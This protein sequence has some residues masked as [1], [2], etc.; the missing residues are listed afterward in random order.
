MAKGKAKAEATTRVGVAWRQD[1]PMSQELRNSFDFRTEEGEPMEVEL[2]VMNAQEPDLGLE[3]YLILAESGERYAKTLGGLDLVARIL[4]GHTG[5]R[6]PSIALLS[7]LDRDTL[8]QKTSNVD[9]FIV[10]SFPLHQ[11]PPQGPITLRLPSVTKW[12]YLCKYALTRSGILNNIRHAVQNAIALGEAGLP[13]MQESVKQ[14]RGLPDLLDPDLRGWLVTFDT[15]S[16]PSEKLRSSA[17]LL[18][19]LDRRI[20]ALAEPGATRPASAARRK[21][22]VMLVEDEAPTAAHVMAM[23]D[24]RFEVVPF[25]DG[26]E[27]LKELDAG[28]EQY[29]ALVCDLE[30]LKSNRFDQPAIGIDVLE[31][32]ASHHPHIARRVITGLGRRGVHELL[33]GM[34]VEHVLFKAHL[35]HGRDSLFVEFLND[36]ELD[37]DS[38]RV[39]KRMIGPRNTNWLDVSRE[40]QEDSSGGGYKSFYYQLQR[41][42]LDRFTKMWLDIESTID[43]VVNNQDVKIKCDFGG[44][45]DA[46]TKMEKIDRE[47]DVVFLQ[48]LLTHRLVMLTKYRPGERVWYRNEDDRSKSYKHL[49]F[50]EG[51]PLM[52]PAIY[53]GYLG[54]G[55]KNQNVKTPKEPDRLVYFDLKYEQLFLEELKVLKKYPDLRKA[56]EAD[57]YFEHEDLCCRLQYALDVIE[58]QRKKEPTKA[59]FTGDYPK[60]PENPYEID[61]AKAEIFLSQLSSEQRLRGENRWRK[62]I[63]EELEDFKWGRKGAYVDAE[64]S[65]DY[66]KLP[67]ALKT[68]F[69]RCIDSMS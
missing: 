48:L 60:S 13:R 63:F 7:L 21:I 61:E 22:K 37:A 38:L 27:A 10:K 44:T 66:H 56:L 3:H 6:P 34:P 31:R 68:L 35:N 32:A 2:L 20:L 58:E 59:I 50:W 57:F 69:D 53:R 39:M 64:G 12:N 52:N 67:T 46:K 1:V 18:G 30:L 19:M 28:G 54:F 49:P 17:E 41:V 55:A 29:Q 4:K 26:V 33:R 23:F 11:V 62:R 51:M 24:D 16:T 14:L 45:R 36:L 42:R 40:D 47:D 43:S 65:P 15:L 25:E 9:R 8:W 5:H